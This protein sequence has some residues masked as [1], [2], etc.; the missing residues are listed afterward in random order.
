MN[1]FPCE[2]FAFIPTSPLSSLPPLTPPGGE[3]GLS[4]VEAVMA[5]STE[6][7][8]DPELSPLDPVDI[9]LARLT[10]APGPMPEAL[11]YIP[12]SLLLLVSDSLEEVRLGG[13]GGVLPQAVAADS[14]C[15][16]FCALRPVS[17]GGVWGC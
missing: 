9:R 8:L 5:I 3:V 2:N 16:S 6:Q 12:E 4:V 15:D 13:R 11:A 1:S 10:L 7:G 14:S 17:E